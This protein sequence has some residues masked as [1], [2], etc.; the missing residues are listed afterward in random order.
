MV[1]SPGSRFRRMKAVG[2]GRTKEQKG[3]P[4]TE[5]IDSR[6]PALYDEG[7]ENNIA[8]TGKSLSR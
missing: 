4:L 5:L 3:V 8:F 2:P 6:S 7:L 1:A